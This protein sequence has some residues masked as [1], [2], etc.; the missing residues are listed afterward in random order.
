MVIHNKP[1]NRAATSFFP[2]GKDLNSLRP[3]STFYPE[4]S[5]AISTL[6]N[7]SIFD[8]FHLPSAGIT[9]LQYLNKCT[10]AVRAAVKKEAAVKMAPKQ[11][12]YYNEQFHANGSV[13]NIVEWRS[14][15]NM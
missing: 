2:Q 7:R 14:D 10:N 15:Q 13:Q 4:S 12:F 8:S 5:S 1:Q 9:Y 6:P 3:A 11:Q